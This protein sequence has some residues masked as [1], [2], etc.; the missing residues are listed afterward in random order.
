VAEGRDE[1]HGK[2]VSTGEK[3]IKAGKDVIDFF[4]KIF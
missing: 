3:I 4:R 2:A 1:R